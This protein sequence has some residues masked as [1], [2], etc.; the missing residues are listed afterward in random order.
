[1]IRP[2]AG[3]ADGLCPSCA[4]GRVVRSG[5]GSV[6]RRCALSATDARYAKYPPQPVLRCHGFAPAAAEAAPFARESAPD[7][8]LD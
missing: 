2:P 3:A 6:F 5:R 1:M 7:A 8:A 4:H